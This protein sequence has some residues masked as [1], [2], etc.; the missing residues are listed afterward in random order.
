MEIRFDRETVVVVQNSTAIRKAH[1]WNK[2][3]N[4]KRAEQYRF[5]DATAA[6]TPESQ[7]KRKTATTANNDTHTDNTHTLTHSL[8]NTYPIYS[9]YTH[10]YNTYTH[11]PTECIY[12]A[13]DSMVIYAGLQVVYGCEWVVRESVQHRETA[14]YHI[15]C[16]K[17]LK[18]FV[19]VSCTH[20]HYRRCLIVIWNESG[21]SSKA[22]KQQL[23][24]AE[25]LSHSISVCQHTLYLGEIFLKFTVFSSLTSQQMSK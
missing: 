15:Q 6:W 2:N 13:T 19:L 22:T 10:I 25:H 14:A 24:G 16:Q 12:Y 21:D 23:G 1:R 8:A 5:A 11:T 20:T 4:N 9:D 3:N 7:P 18:I 17:N